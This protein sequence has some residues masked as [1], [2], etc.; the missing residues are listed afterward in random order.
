MKLNANQT[1]S[2]LAALKVCVISDDD[3]L[4]DCAKTQLYRPIDLNYNSRG[5]F[6]KNLQS[7]SQTIVRSI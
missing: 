5:R 3:S 6:S 1:K 2:N 7:D 4:H